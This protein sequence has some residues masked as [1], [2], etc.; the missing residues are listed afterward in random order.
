MTSDS[1]PPDDAHL[2]LL[3]RNQALLHDMNARIARL[4]I[5]L[6]V[7]LHNEQQIADAIHG[8]QTPQVALERRSSGERRSGARGGTAERRVSYIREELR[9]LLVLRYGAQTRLVAEIGLSATRSLMAG[10]EAQLDRAGFAPG[11]DGVDRN[12]YQNTDGSGGGR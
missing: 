12:G 8:L 6:G 2:L 11:A 1:L 3:E 7:S 5:A 9:G 4:A 10:A